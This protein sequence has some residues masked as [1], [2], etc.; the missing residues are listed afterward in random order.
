MRDL[1]RWLKAVVTFSRFAWTQRKGAK[2]YHVAVIHEGREVADWWDVVQAAH[3]WWFQAY[4]AS[5]PEA[6][7]PPDL[8]AELRELL[9]H[10][11]QDGA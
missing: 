6:P 9:K 7:P 10:E 1:R 3:S 8:D 2:I 4:H 11:G 5:L